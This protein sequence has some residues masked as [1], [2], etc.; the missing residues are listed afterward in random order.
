M[1]PVGEIGV[2][3]SA[4][5]TGPERP[6]PRRRTHHTS[7]STTGVQRHQALADLDESGRNGIRFDVDGV[8]RSNIERTEEVV[9]VPPAG[10]TNRPHRMS[11]LDEAYANLMIRKKQ[12]QDPDQLRRHLT[13]GEV[14]TRRCR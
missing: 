11:G 2:P 3:E 9:I 5:I 8:D 1:D 13:A 14:R 10:R 4:P 12:S 6:V 7:R